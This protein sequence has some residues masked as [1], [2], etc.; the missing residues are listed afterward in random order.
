MLPVK[1]NFRNKYKDII[2]RGCK[3]EIETQQHVLENCP[4]IHKDNTSIVLI[5]HY[6]TE[7]I[8]TLKKASK[9]ILLI[10]ERLVQSDVP[11]A[12]TSNDARPGIRTRT[13]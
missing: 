6:F 13:R 10:L 2:C 8:Q 3:A 1:N 5:T 11:I 7:D 12:L 9:N 4:E